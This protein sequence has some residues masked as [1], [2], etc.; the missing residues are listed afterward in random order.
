MAGVSTLVLRCPCV[1]WGHLLGTFDSSLQCA[2]LEYIHSNWHL[3]GSCD[4]L[5][6]NPLGA[7]SCPFG[8][9][10]VF[11]FD[12]KAVSDQ[13]GKCQK[14]KQLTQGRN[15]ICWLGALPDILGCVCFATVI[16]LWNTHWLC[17]SLRKLSGNPGG[18]SIPC[19]SNRLPWTNRHM[20]ACAS[21]WRARE[22]WLG[23]ERAGESRPC[24]KDKPQFLNLPPMSTLICIPPLSLSRTPSLT[25]SLMVMTESWSLI[26]QGPGLQGLFYNP[27]LGLLLEKRDKDHIGCLE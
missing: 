15:E 1:M 14:R 20:D 7:W 12:F 23:R 13:I 11:W 5:E 24:V 16:S 4:V 27:F 19:A 17:S 8:L 3:P 2:C 25:F 21:I 9:C 10:S 22:G 26:P 18:Q 6:S